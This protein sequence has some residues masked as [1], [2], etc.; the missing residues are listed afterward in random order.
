MTYLKLKAREGMNA[1]GIT[2][3]G[4]THAWFKGIIYIV[5]KAEMAKLEAA[6]S[7]DKFD[8]VS[9]DDFD[10][11]FEEAKKLEKIN[12]NHVENI[13]AKSDRV[14]AEEK[15]EAERLAAE[16]KAKETAVADGPETDADPKPEA[17]PE[18]ESTPT[19]GDDK[20][21]TEQEAFDLNRDAQEMVLRKRGVA[22]KANYKEDTLVKKILESNP[23]A[24]E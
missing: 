3:S 5:D 14:E 8:E 19:T 20:V 11:Q 24:T 21:Y 22:F 4:I 15:A 18:Q 17:A 7:V 6:N 9:K 2:I 1:R 23:V 16:E 12:K 10:K 13:Q